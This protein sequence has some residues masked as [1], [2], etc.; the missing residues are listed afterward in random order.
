MLGVSYSKQG[1]PDGFSPATA[2]A[3][4]AAPSPPGFGAFALLDGPGLS[5]GLGLGF[6]DELTALALTQ[7]PSVLP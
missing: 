5:L 2:A 4:L 6:Q 1:R 3:Q 7:K